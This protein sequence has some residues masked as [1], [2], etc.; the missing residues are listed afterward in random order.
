MG[1]EEEKEEEDR[2]QEEDLAKKD[3]DSS[4]QGASQFSD[5]AMYQ[6][7]AV[8]THQSRCC[9]SPPPRTQRDY[10]YSSVR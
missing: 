3:V 6:L 10:Q 9:I 4:L 1:R 5:S 8:I 7:R 2:G